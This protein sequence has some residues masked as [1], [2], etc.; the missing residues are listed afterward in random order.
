VTR[1][2]TDW[3]EFADLPVVRAGGM[4]IVSLDHRDI[5]GKIVIDGCVSVQL[6]DQSTGFEFEICDPTQVRR[7]ITDM[8]DTLVLRDQ[9]EMSWDGEDILMSTH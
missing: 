5:G 6:G 4:T 3:A 8:G 1:E 2:I 9:L 7:E